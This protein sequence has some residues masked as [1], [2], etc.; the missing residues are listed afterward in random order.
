MWYLREAGDL[1]NN[2]LSSKYGRSIS[3]V[4]EYC[5]Y[6]CKSSHMHTVSLSESVDF[7]KFDLIPL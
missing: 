3:I 4:Q 2:N 7:S 5:K 6:T 1:T